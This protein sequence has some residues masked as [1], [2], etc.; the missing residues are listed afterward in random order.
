LAQAVGL[1]RSIGDRIVWVV[2]F[3]FFFMAIGTPF[4]IIEAA[5]ADALLAENTTG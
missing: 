4:E 1:N 5:R 3:K 2:F